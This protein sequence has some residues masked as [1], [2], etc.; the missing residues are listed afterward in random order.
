MKDISYIYEMIEKSDITLI[1]YTFKVERIKDEFISKLPC[2]MVGE[3]DSSF[4]IKAF[5]RDIKINQ[6]L[7]NFE[8]FKYLVIDI[9]DI[10]TSGDSN[11]SMERTKLIKSII[12]TIRMD[13]YKSYPKVATI[14]FETPYKLIITSPLHK[15]ISNT[16]K[17]FQVNNFMGG[18]R[19]MYM[20]D[21]A[22][23]INKPKL[24]DS[25]SIKVLKNRHDFDN[26][27]ISFDKLT[28][29]NYICN[30]G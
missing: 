27:E 9:S 4:S 17:S 8:Y 22:F 24:F 28:D 12:E 18:N 21:F 23:T 30:H 16:D 2:I 29:Y 26:V 7:D 14:E 13:M 20:A 1:E 3:I 5:L 11:I 10:I 19:T 25:P 6:V 15:S